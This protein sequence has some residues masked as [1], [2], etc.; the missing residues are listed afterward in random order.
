MEKEAQQPLG[1]MLKRGKIR[2]HFMDNIIRSKRKL[3]GMN[4]QLQP[5]IQI[6]VRI[7]FRGIGR[8]EKHLNPRFVPFQPGTHKLAVMHTQIVHDKEYLSLG[9]CNQTAHKFYQFLLIHRI[10]VNHVP[11]TSLLADC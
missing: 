4:T 1:V 11:Q 5:M 7:A 3:P 10:T 9:F 8:Q 2:A 6:L